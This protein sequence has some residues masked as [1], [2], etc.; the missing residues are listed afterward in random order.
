M[1]T[2]SFIR[3]TIPP[4]NTA[5]AGNTHSSRTQYYHLTM[6]NMKARS[7]MPTNS[8][9]NTGHMNVNVNGSPWCNAT[10]GGGTLNFYK[11]D[12]G[13]WNLGEIPSVSLHEWGH[14]MDDF[15][16]SGGDSRPVE[17]RAD[18]TAILQTHDSCIGRGFY[19]SGNCHGEG[20][21]CLDCNRCAIAEACPEDA[22]E[23]PS[24][25]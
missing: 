19:L 2:P 23:R 22:F 1:R 8:W 15:D 14:S 4:V 9:L 6:V 7:Y 25:T 20:D 16:G 11:A 12:S 5:G 3:V 21:T 18:W 13:C 24:S 17:T 10:S